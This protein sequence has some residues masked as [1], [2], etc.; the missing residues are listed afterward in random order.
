M[1]YLLSNVTATAQAD[2]LVTAGTDEILVKL[3]E[4]VQNRPP[5]V[6]EFGRVSRQVKW[7]TFV[8][9]GGQFALYETYTIDCEISSWLP[10]SDTFD[11][12][13][14]ALQVTQRAWQL[15]AY[16]ETTIRNDPSLGGLVETAYPSGGD[17]TEPQP[18]A[19]GTGLIVA[20]SYPIHVESFI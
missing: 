18:D 17:A 5:D 13:A 16:A 7:E 4:E 12:T 15:V 2:P 14:A 3:G 6:I 10:Y 20:I 1:A 11:D 19:K 8:G 9:S